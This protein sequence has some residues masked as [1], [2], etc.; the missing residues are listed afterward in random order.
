MNLIDRFLRLL[1]DRGPAPRRVHRRRKGEESTLLEKKVKRV[2]I[3]EEEAKKRI[4]DHVKLLLSIHYDVDFALC[5]ADDKLLKLIVMMAE[6]LK[7]EERDIQ[8]ITTDLYLKY[9]EE[10]FENIQYYLKWHEN[11]YTDFRKTFEI[12]NRAH[13]VMQRTQV[14]IPDLGEIIKEMNVEINRLEDDEEGLKDEGFRRFIKYFGAMLGIEITTI[15][16]FVYQSSLPTVGKA[17][18]MF[19]GIFLAGYITYYVFGFLYKRC[20]IT[21]AKKVLKKYKIKGD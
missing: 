16:G 20:I 19:T 14:S 12:M 8:E 10:C 13:R 3:S 21:G 15:T 1:Y 9:A 11:N 18:G 4:I 2:T 17:Y 7:A 5:K 6:E